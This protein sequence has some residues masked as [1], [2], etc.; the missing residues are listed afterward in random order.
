M[1]LAGEEELPCFRER[2]RQCMHLDG[3]LSIAQNYSDS[4]KIRSHYS[5]RDYICFSILHTG[6]HSSV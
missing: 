2:V 5:K 4:C 6:S 3:V 1:G